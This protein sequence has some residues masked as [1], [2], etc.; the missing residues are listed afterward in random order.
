MLACSTPEPGKPCRFLYNTVAESTSRKRAV[1]GMF[2]PECQTDF[3][4]G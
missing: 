4:C 3:L 1:Y 2:T